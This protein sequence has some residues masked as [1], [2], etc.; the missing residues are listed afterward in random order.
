MN[1]EVDIALSLGKQY[2]LEIP[3]VKITTV[4]TFLF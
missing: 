4:Q 3:F 1:G 2:F